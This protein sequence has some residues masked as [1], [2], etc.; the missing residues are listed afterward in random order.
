[1]P[2]PV[3]G[4]ELSRR[5]YQD[6]VRPALDAA[7]PGLRHSAALLGRGSEVLG[8]DDEMSRD[9]DW[10]PRVLL[11]LRDDDDEAH[12]D[13]LRQ[14]LQLELPARFPDRPAHHS[15]H[16]VRGYLR[17]QLAVDVDS[18]LDAR[19]WLTLSEQALLMMTAGA[20]FHDE[21]G[22]QA[23]RRRFAYYPRDVWLY[24]MVAAWWRVH[25]EANVV[26]RAGY[27][28][29]ELGSALIGSRLVH[30]LMRLCFLLE[31]RYAPYSKWF[32]TAFASLDCGAELSPILWRAL[33][34]PSWQE[35]EQ[36]LNDAYA[37]VAALH[38]ASGITDPV[39]VHEERM[40]DRPFAVLWGDFPGVLA[41]A[42]E[43]PEVRG[44]A[45]RWPVGGPDRAR[46]QLWDVRRRSLL[47]PLFD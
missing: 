1:M 39:P 32:G 14:T 34:A 21:V 15:V 18:E 36:A 6:E 35:R 41:E 29:D 27:S 46:E 4:Q 13:A 42:I 44:I 25:P 37:A 9:H 8:Y 19:D 22:L 45:E 31:R 26:G 10:G 17:D 38:N 43:D 40:W 11:F 7:F 33:R 28:G 3:S 16:T 20:V 12:G 5:Y 2:V 30:D 47:R 23:V 24:L